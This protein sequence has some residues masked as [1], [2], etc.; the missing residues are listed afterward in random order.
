MTKFYQK[1]QIAFAITLGIVMSGVMFAPHQA[2]AVKIPTPATALVYGDSIMFES[3][4]TLYGK[5]NAKKGWTA[6]MHAYP[7]FALCDWQDELEQELALY[8]PQ[9]V[10]IETQ[11]NTYTNC[12]RD[13]NGNLPAYGSQAWKDKYRADFNKFF[14]T[15]TAAGS[16]VLY[17]KALPRGDGNPA[18]KALDSIAQQEAGKF[19]GVSISAKARN[20]VTKTGKFTWTKKCYAFETAA[21]GCNAAT[22]QITVRNPDGIHL[23]PVAYPTNESFL[24]GCSVYS[25]GAY[26]F[27]KTMF[28]ATISPPAP[29]LP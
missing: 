12:M 6:Y 2:S 22:N 23:C 26:R 24:A 18:Y 13:S 28:A 7:G 25:G 4:W 16:K 14:A 10:S 15:A 19:H 21:M 5:F 27:G 29:I 17:F 20:S 1:L 11:G 8:H 3:Y 9:I